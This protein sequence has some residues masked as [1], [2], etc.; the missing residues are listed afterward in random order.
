MGA[1]V[2]ADFREIKEVREF[3]ESAEVGSGGFLWVLV[4]S[5]GG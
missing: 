5:C 4:S 1:E 2:C 3:R